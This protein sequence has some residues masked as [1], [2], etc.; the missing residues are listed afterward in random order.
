MK[1]LSIGLVILSVFLMVDSV[2]PQL[3]SI[4]GGVC[5]TG[6]ELNWYCR[7]A[8]E[9]LRICDALPGCTVSGREDY[10]RCCGGLEWWAIVLIVLAVVVVIGVIIGVVLCLRR[11]NDNA[12]V[13]QMNPN[14]A[15]G[16]YGQ[17]GNVYGPP[18]NAYGPP[19]NAYGPAGN[20]YGP[21]GNAYG[22]PGKVYGQP[23]NVYD[24]TQPAGALLILLLDRLSILYNHFFSFLMNY[25]TYRSSGTSCCRWFCSNSSICRSPGTSYSCFRCRESASVARKGVIPDSPM[26]YTT[27][28][29]SVM[30]MHRSDHLI[31]GL[32]GTHLACEL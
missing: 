27:T 19:G 18:G 5:P 10:E 22:P 11:K 31:S 29:W 13:G 20:A 2:P 32:S 30:D 28:S 1:S 24:Q 16:A 7:H 14:Y 6:A 21:P 3:R 4:R 17:P 25:A 23:G 15:A 8:R 26:N 9:G 12:G